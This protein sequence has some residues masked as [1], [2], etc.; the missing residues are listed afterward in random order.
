MLGRVGHGEGRTLLFNAHMDVVPGGE[1]WTVDA[2]GGERCD[3]G[4]F[5]RGAVYD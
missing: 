5:G 1:D 2:F 4:V 3:C